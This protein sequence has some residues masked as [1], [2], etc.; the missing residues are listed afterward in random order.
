MSNAND[1]VIEQGVLTKY[2]GPGG[3][4]VIPEGVTVIEKKTFRGCRRLSSVTVPEGVTTIGN[5]AFLGCTSL[6]SVTIPESVTTI[7][8]RAF[9]VAPA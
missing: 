9:W 2:T 4:V 8:N 1:L 7:G 5:R 3:D 6:S